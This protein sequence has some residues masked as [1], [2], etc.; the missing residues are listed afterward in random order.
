MKQNVEHF[1]AEVDL[2]HKNWT[3]LSKNL[4]LFDHLTDD[5]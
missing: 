1:W 4:T 5:A 2:A 3:E